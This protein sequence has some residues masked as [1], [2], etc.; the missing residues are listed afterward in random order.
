VKKLDTWL[1][2]LWLEGGGGNTI[3][4]SYEMMAWFYAYRCDLTKAKRKIL[5]ITGDEDLYKKLPAKR[6]KELFGGRGVGETMRTETVFRD[7]L[8]RFDGHVYLIHR[9]YGGAG[10]GDDTRIVR[11]WRR[12]L[13]KDRVLRLGTD[14]A[15]GDVMLGII[16][17]TLGGQ[18][19]EHYCEAMKERKNLDSGKP[20]PQSPERIAEVRKTLKPLTNLPGYGKKPTATEPTRKKTAAKAVSKAAARKKTPS[21]RKP[22]SAKATKSATKT[23]KTSTRKKT[24]N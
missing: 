4:E 24:G 8:D 10:S 6:L 17:L 14:K 13:G 18:T 9:D 11:S 5:I 1:K 16:S 3:E 23:K 21:S 15:V 2:R 12:L 22:A 7:L 19:L 20:E